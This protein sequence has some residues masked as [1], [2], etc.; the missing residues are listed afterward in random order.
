MERH[1]QGFS[2]SNLSIRQEKRKILASRRIPES[3]TLI[4]LRLL[5]CSCWEELLIDTTIQAAFVAMAVFAPNGTRFLTDAFRSCRPRTFCQCLR[6]QPSHR[7]VPRLR[8]EVSTATAQLSEMEVDTPSPPRWSYTPPAMKAPVSHRPRS[9]GGRHEVNKDPR[10]LDEMYINFLGRGGEAMFSEE[11]K[12]LAVTHKS[13]D[14]GRRGFND[15]LAFLGMS[16]SG[17]VEAIRLTSLRQKDSRATSI[18]G[19]TQ[20]CRLL[21]ISYPALRILSVEHH[22]LTLHWTESN[23]LQAAQDHGS[24]IIDKYRRLLLSTAYHRSCGGCPKM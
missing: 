20:P 21:H 7:K 19:P 9:S 6:I 17:V 1:G 11:T 14:H 10:R 24:R 8:R 23:V 15:R 4:S 12:W 18:T 13:F 16:Q 5:V 3:L 2:V 22:S